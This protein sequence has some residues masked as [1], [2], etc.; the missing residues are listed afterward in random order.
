[1]NTNPMTAT[2]EGVLQ[3]MKDAAHVLVRDGYSAIPSDLREA[4]RT[5]EAMA[6]AL[7]FLLP[8]I[9]SW[10]NARWDQHLR[11]EFGDERAGPMIT[12]LT[13][14]GSTAPA[15]DAAQ[16]SCSMGFGCDEAGI[17]YAA[18]HGQFDRCP[19]YPA[20][21]AEDGEL[22]QAEQEQE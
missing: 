16:S 19:K 3:V 10:T 7:Q 1:M 5:V 14:F 22:Q 15:G 13:A 4:I 20:A 12:A 21:P 17:C 18:A 2:A 11:Y 9:G 8:R 6:E